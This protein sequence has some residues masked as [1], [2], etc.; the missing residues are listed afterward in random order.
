MN[1]GIQG[2]YPPGSVFKLIASAIALENNLVSTEWSVNC[3]GA[4]TYGDRTFH[5]W[6]KTGHG[7]INMKN[8]LKHSCN[9]YF[10][11]LIQKF[12]LKNGQIFVILFGFGSRTGIDLPEK[13]RV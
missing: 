11:K 6:N 8:S 4:Y 3:N 5:C 2:T 9:I 12:H 1:R 7:K 10:Y 13:E